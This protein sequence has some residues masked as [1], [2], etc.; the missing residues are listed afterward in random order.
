MFFS[1]EYVLSLKP[2]FCYTEVL[3]LSGM[4]LTDRGLY[5]M[6]IKGRIFS[7]G[8]VYFQFTIFVS[9]FYVSEIS[10]AA[11]K[12]DQ[13]SIREILNLAFAVVTLMGLSIAP[14]ILQSY[15]FVSLYLGKLP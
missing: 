10:V 11:L 6:L 8:K 7:I 12:V 1:P 9:L 14:F 15:F 4:F 5:K 13:K 2:I 3:I